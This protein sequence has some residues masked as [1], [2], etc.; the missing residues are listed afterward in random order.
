MLNG[1]TLQYTGGAA[2]IDRLFT[3]GTSGGT[4]DVE[5]TR[6]IDL[7]N[8]AA[9]TISGILTLNGNTADTNTLAAVA[10]LAAAT[11]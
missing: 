6:R 5:V 9:I 4:I 2:S 7:N 11:R 3:V 1:G 10:E 8:P